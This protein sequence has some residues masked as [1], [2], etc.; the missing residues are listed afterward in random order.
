[1]SPAAKVKNYLNKNHTSL[2]WKVKKVY[3][4]PVFRIYGYFFKDNIEYGA[5]IMV[6]VE[7]LNV[8]FADI[9]D[10]TAQGFY[11]AMSRKVSEIEKGLN[12]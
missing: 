7:D 10:D 12:K 5:A 4:K 6:N 9:L 2:S 11:N 8:S 1:M 3:N